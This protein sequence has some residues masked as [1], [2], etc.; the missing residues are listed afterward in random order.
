MHAEVVKEVD[1]YFADLE[2]F[3]N[4]KDPGELKSTQYLFA[5]RLALDKVGVMEHYYLLVTGLPEKYMPK[6][7]GSNLDES[8]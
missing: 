2:G 3:L 7:G 8:T 1:A 4:V 6:P 5:V